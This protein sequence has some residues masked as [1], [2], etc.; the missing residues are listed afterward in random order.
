MNVDFGELN[1][2]MLSR[3]R[4]RRTIKKPGRFNDMNLLVFA[5]H[6]LDG[7]EPKSY[8]DALKSVHL[9]SGLKV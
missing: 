3:D 9:I 7:N 8:K 5:L 6:V 4:T 2:Y 1:D